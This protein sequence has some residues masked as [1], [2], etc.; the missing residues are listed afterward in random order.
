VGL[1][2]QLYYR[3]VPAKGRE[4]QVS[5]EQFFYPLDAILDWNRM[6]GRRGFVQFQCV[7]RTQKCFGGLPNLLA[8]HCAS[9]SLLSRGDQDTGRRRSRP[10]VVSHARVTLALDFPRKSGVDTLLASLHALTADYGGRV[11]LAKDSRVTPAQFRRMY[12]RYPFQ[13]SVGAIDH[14]VECVRIV[15][16][17]QLWICPLS[18]EYCSHE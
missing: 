2:N 4:R 9:D 1:F 13:A 6:Y 14:N 10:P 18:L 5:L 11:Y 7:I 16:S 12:P 8:T 15:A 17:L 3:R